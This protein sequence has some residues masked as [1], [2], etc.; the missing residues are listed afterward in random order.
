MLLD[1]LIVFVLYPAMAMMFYGVY[2]L[3]V[4]FNI[5]RARL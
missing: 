4:S 3:W 2:K 1:A 5:W